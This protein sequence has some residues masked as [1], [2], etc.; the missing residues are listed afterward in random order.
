MQWKWWDQ[1][2]RKAHWYRALTWQDVSIQNPVLK[3]HL[4]NQTTQSDHI[5]MENL[6]VLW[7]HCID[8]EGYECIVNVMELRRLHHTWT[9]WAGYHHV[10]LDVS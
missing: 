2:N 4:S 6:F 5:V 1:H 10:P 9:E 3:D 7:I 8:W